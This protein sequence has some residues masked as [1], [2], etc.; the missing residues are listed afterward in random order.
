MGYRGVDDSGIK[1]L[2]S[3]GGGGLVIGRVENNFHEHGT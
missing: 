1:H 2:G 3:A